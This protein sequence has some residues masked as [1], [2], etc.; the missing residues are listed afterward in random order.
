MIETTSKWGNESG[1]RKAGKFIA[2]PACDC[3]GKPTGRD[4]N[5]DDEVCGSTDGPGFYLCSRKR[6]GA[7]T[8]GLD[9]EARRALYTAQRVKNRAG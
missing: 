9:V 4:Y 6:C 2:S 1:E 8:E 3:C 7:K 5:T